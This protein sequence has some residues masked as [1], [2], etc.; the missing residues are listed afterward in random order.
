[1]EQSIEIK[2][3]GSGYLKATIGVQEE[4]FELLETMEFGDLTVTGPN[5]YTYEGKQFKGYIIEGQ[6]SQFLEQ[7][8]AEDGVR[9]ETV[10]G[11]SV[12]Q[13]ADGTFLAFEGSVAAQTGDSQV[14]GLSAVGSMMIK[15]A[16]EL[17][18]TNGTVQS[19][20]SVLWDIAVAQDLRAVFK[21]SD[22]VKGGL[23]D[24]GI[25]V[26][27]EGSAAQ[28][29]PAQPSPVPTQPSAFADIKDHWAATYLNTMV[30]SGVMNGVTSTAMEPDK[31][32][33][34]AEAITM[35]YRAYGKSEVPASQS[36]ADIGDYEWA[37]TPIAW[38][39]EHNVS[40]GIGRNSSGGTLFAPE[41][42]LTREQLVTLLYNA[43]LNV[44]ETAIN[45]SEPPTKP[46]DYSD[47]SDWAVPGVNFGLNAGILSGS[48]INPTGVATRAEFATMLYR[49]GGF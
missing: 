2:E 28:P 16:G 5:V 32:V 25:P 8:T 6:L 39:I 24:A 30:S 46:F 22:K 3:D 34:R 26:T 15:V 11:L 17:V 33:T 36:I 29:S 45:T 42:A 27:S 4:S 43:S 40:N 9:T 47:V 21:I 41:Q 10:D 14:Q 35:L 19:D 48:A 12:Y 20:G 31:Q 49:M 7:D 18:E 13:N 44:T 37:R 1:M 23:V 38:A